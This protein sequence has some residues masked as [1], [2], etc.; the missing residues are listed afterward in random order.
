MD[1]NNLVSFGLGQIG[2]VKG[3]PHRGICRAEVSICIT[4]GLNPHLAGSATRH[5]GRTAIGMPN[6]AVKR[7]AG[8]VSSANL[9]RVIGTSQARL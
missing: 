2:L 5:I 3:E 4:L 1:E 9:A 8:V 6:G 7:F